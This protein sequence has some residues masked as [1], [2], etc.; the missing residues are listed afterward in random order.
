MA[1]Y[2]P[3]VPENGATFTSTIHKSSY[4]FLRTAKHLGHHILITGG[5]RGIGRAIAL[6]FARAG[7]KAIAVADIAE[8]PGQ[9]IGDIAA[10][11]REN[12]HDAPQVVIT[13][14][15]V[16]DEESVGKCARY[17]E[18]EFKGRLDILVN[19]AGFMTPALPISESDSGSWW[20]TMEVNLKGVY[21]MSKYFI[22]LL[23]SAPEGL[24]TMININSVAAHNLRPMASAYGTSKSAV[25]KL[26]EF[27]MAEAG[28]RGLLAY[29]VHPGAILT[30]L[31]EKGMPP[32]TLP[33]LNDSV[34]L[35][36]DT[37]AWLSSEKREWLAGRYLSC[38]WDMNELLERQSEIVEGDKLKVRLVV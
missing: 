4:P 33:T 22:P 25:L 28:S 23:L 34:D 20:Q 38:T 36:G 1:S 2:P 11:A 21:L 16:T 9:L 27:L 17:I 14:L 6:S 32:E 8:S 13:R 30:E 7:A 31:A 15:D 12:G 19:N 37:V 5:T 24:R 29:S 18:S 26:T 10:A 35:T 3:I